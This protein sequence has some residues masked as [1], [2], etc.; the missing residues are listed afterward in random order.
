MPFPSAWKAIF[1]AFV[2]TLLSLRSCS[3]AF[4]PSTTQNPSSTPTQWNTSSRRRSFDVVPLQARNPFFGGGGNKKGE[5]EERVPLKSQ[6]SQERRQQ[7]GIGDDEDE[8]DLGLALAANT[9][10]TISKVVAG[11]F[12]LVMIALLVAG[13]VVPSLTDYG[14]GVCSPIQN[15][16]RC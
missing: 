8:Y 6:I 13:V 16:G 15:A 11:S 9:D 3:A 10:D 4:S 1:A 14:E 12:I 5:E 2:V 7:L